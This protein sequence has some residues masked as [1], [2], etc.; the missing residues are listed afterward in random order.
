MVLTVLRA[1]VERIGVRAAG[2]TVVTEN[3]LFLVVYSLP[4]YPVDPSGGAFHDI[5]LLALLHLALALGGTI[6][7][8]WLGLPGEL[9]LPA[10]LVVG[11]ALLKP[12]WSLYT[13]YQPSHAD[14]DGNE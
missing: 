13:A 8:W 14:G 5:Q 12:F 3:L 6:A 2:A 1:P 10:F 9:L 7:L 11:V 4:M